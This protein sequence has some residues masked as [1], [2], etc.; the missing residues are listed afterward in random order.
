IPHGASGVKTPSGSARTVD[1]VARR[2]L[3]TSTM[4]WTIDCP[5]STHSVCRGPISL[6]MTCLLRSHLLGH[7][8]PGH[9]P[10][11]RTF[12]IALM[13][14]ACPKTPGHGSTLLHQRPEGRRH[15]RHVVTDN[16]SLYY[17]GHI[18]FSVD[19]ASVCR[20]MPGSL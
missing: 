19:R 6:C 1:V 11:W 13:H 9:A 7:N 2:P 18:V 14:K 17:T 8:P 12:P 10:A 20:A 16:R 15:T 4:V 5:N 3:C